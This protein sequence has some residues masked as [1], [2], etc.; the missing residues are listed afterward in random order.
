MT[1]N[2]NKTSEKIPIVSRLGSHFPILAGD[3]FDD[4]AYELNSIR[5]DCVILNVNEGKI[6][7]ANQFNII[8]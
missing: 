6:Q 3:I 4:F 7:K 2:V 8:G 5:F 1:K